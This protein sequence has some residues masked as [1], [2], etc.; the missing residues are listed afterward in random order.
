MSYSTKVIRE[1][2]LNLVKWPV[3]FNHILQIHYTMPVYHKSEIWRRTWKC[4]NSET[5]YLTCNTHKRLRLLCS[6][7]LQK[8]AMSYLSPASFSWLCNNGSWLYYL[9]DYI[10]RINHISWNEESAAAKAGE[11][12]GEKTSGCRRRIWRENVL[13]S[14]SEASYCCMKTFSISLSKWRN[15]EA[16]ISVPMTVC[17]QWQYMT[18]LL[19]VT[20]GYQ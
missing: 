13:L 15:E 11:G 20:R 9:A 6:L 3:L 12:A 19:S 16:I 1:I 4:W 7:N 14:V 10:S 17:N 2:M 5:W 18:S 8:V